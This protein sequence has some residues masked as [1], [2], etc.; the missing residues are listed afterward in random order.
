MA[1]KIKLIKTEDGSHSL[2]NEDLNETYHSQHG[3]YNESTHVFI[4]QGLKYFY[5]EHFPKQ[6]KILE[7]GFGTGLNALL[8]VKELGLLP[9]V[10]INYT[11]LEPYPLTKEIV[12]GL[13]YTDLDMLESYKDQ[14]YK[15]HEAEWGENVEITDRF[16]INKQKLKLQD[17]NS[18]EKYDII[19][20][21]AFAPNKQGEL[22]EYDILEKV[23]QM[24]ARPSCLVTYCAKG[25]FKRDL[26]SLDMVVETL[27]GPPGKKEMVRGVKV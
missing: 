11:T 18:E 27:P 1:D 3:A 13:N 19:Y 9:N 14:F 5:F 23:A 7:I 15:I 4:K 21:D 22:W 20:F 24:M 10:K 16:T 26:A 25:Q 6:I 8:T 2:Y 17:F 12:E